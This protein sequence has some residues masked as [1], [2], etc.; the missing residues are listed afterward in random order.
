MERSLKWYKIR[1]YTKYGQADM[2]IDSETASRGLTINEFVEASGLSSIFP[3]KDAYDMFNIEISAAY[4]LKDGAANH[5][6]KP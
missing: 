2:V 3:I 5:A 6:F 4:P 1:V